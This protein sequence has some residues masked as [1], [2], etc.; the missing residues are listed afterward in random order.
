M[1]ENFESRSKDQNESNVNARGGVAQMSAH[2]PDCLCGSIPDS[3]AEPTIGPRLAE[4]RWLAM[5][6]AI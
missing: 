2:N 6:T 4:T 5:R 3:F 1:N